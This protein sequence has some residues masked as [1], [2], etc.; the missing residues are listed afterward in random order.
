MFDRIRRL[1]WN[2]R[3]RCA[4]ATV[5][6]RVTV[7][8]PLY[9]YVGEDA[10]LTIGDS[11]SF[12]QNVAISANRRCIV[13]VG[14]RVAIGQNTSLIPS[15]HNIDDGTL[16][17]TSGYIRIGNDVWIGANVAIL[18]NVTIG[19]GAVVGAGS[20]V[21]KDVPAYSVSYGNPARVHRVLR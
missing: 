7:T 12:A 20:V 1:W 3:I 17:C 18:R 15:N 11:V 10:L 13:T 2:H 14:D 16:P 19:D 8:H 21:T 6:K 4:G 5:G 9:L